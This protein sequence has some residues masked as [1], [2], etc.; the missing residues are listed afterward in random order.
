M[1]GPPE[2]A[3]DAPDVIDY[4]AG[5]APDSPLA[6]LRAWRPDVVR[7]AQGSYQAVLEPDDPAGVSRRERELIALRVA[8]L[9]P[10]P[11][12]TAWHRDRLRALGATEADL[13][14]IANGPVTTLAPREQALLRHTDLLT[15]EP[16]AA[17]P[18]DLAA[19][20]EAGFGPREIVTIAQLIAYASFAV[21][22]LAGLRVLGEEG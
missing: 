9:T 16:G 11:A 17:T 20:K 10:D 1:G 8:A 5:V 3:R 15:R 7:H 2:T 19:L 14:A 6:R 12:L 13:A 21:R 22:V 4:L 18:A